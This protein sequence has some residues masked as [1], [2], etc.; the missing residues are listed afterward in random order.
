MQL[1][2]LISRGR[3][4]HSGDIRPSTL[5]C[6]GLKVLALN[7]VASGEQ[8]GCASTRAAVE[9]GSAKGGSTGC[10]KPQGDYGGGGH[11]GDGDKSTVLTRF[12]Y[13]F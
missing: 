6:Y 2:L 12:K 1:C 11:G 8:L 13:L 5:S 7:G 3:N 9:G 4:L 10:N